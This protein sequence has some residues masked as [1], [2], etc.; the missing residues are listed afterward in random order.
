MLMDEIN[1]AAG[2]AFEGRVETMGKPASP[3]PS[4]ESRTFDLPGSIWA[5]MFGS[6][7]LFFGGLAIAVGGTFD[8][9]GMVI[10]SVS[11]AV[12]YFGT[13]TVLV[14]IAKTHRAAGKERPA[15]GPWSIDTLT[16]RL[17]YGAAAAQ[18]LT[19]PALFGFFALCIV[20]I[21]SIAIPG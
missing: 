1:V 20:I 16:G 14:R 13:A 9:L 5:M 21:R 19:V 10:I 8:A 11:F 17:G 3:A 6:Y 2:T 12:M 18:I 15:P 7:A 4:H